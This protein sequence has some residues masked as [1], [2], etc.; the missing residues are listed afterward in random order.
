MDNRIKTKYKID[1]L[2]LALEITKLRF[3]GAEPPDELILRARAIGLLADVSE[4]ELNK[5]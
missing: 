2:K 4:T 5:L 3:M 1:Y